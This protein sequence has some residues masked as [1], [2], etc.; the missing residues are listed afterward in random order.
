MAGRS[1]Q[2]GNLAAIGI[3]SQA[4]CQ[5]GKETERDRTLAEENATTEKREILIDEIIKD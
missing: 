4:F 5:S 1:R 2:A 3:A